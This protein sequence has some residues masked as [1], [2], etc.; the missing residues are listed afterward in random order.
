MPAMSPA[1]LLTA[2]R[3]PERSGGLKIRYPTKEL[4]LAAV[5]TIRH[6]WSSVTVTAPDG[7]LVLQLENS[8]PS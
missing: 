8:D 4:A 3:D 1:Y 5:D 2:R 6:L 7:A